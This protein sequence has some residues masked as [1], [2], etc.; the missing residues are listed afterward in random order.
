MAAAMR[1]DRNR[2]LQNATDTWYKS[3]YPRVDQANGRTYLNEVDDV[4]DHQPMRTV[5]MSYL[6]FTAS[7]CIR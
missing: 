2:V 6:V 1:S 4:K 3:W 5:D 7:Y